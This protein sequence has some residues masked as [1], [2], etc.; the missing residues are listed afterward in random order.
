MGY[1]D[2]VP[3]SGAGKF[4]ASLH[5]LLGIGVFS[6]LTANISAFLVKQNEMQED[7][8]EHELLK[9]IQRRLER[10]ENRLKT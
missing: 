2:V 9:D 6:L 4:F 5:I 8:E 10:I 7:A 3:V 1:G